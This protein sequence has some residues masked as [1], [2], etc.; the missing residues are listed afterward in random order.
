MIHGT[1]KAYRAGCSCCPCR[2]ANA[3][4]QAQRRLDRRAGRLTLGLRISPAHARKRIRQLEADDI[5]ERDLA[6]RLGLKHHRLR[7]HPSAITVRKHLRIILEYRRLNGE[8]P[9]VPLNV[10]A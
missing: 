4:Y 7:L 9:D 5:T 3:A 2:A 10:S 8:G 1:R 6:R